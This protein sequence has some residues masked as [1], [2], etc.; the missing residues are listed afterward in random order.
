[1]TN[2]EIEIMF[3]NINI[4]DIREKLKQLGAE[5]IIPM[6]KMRRVALRTHEMRN[7]KKGAFVRV[8]DEG[9]KITLTYKCLNKESLY[10]DEY[11]VIVNDFDRA[12]DFAKA[13][14][15]GN[16]ATNVFQESKREEWILNNAKVCI[17]VWPWIN[18][19][20]EIEGK[21]EKEIMA[22]SKQLG[23][24][25]SDGIFGGANNVHKAVY[26][27]FKE[28]DLKLSDFNIKFGDPKP[29][30]FC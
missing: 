14:L 1:M 25:W 22:T 15:E 11:E 24:N 2:Q 10:M 13:L 17:D 5:L 16:L 26:P 19:Y 3:L 8:R 9:N 20:L 23:F 18:P 6:R 21:S 30:I 7:N 27:K 28:S 4:D 29:E 12:V